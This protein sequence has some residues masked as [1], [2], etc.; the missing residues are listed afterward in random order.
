MQVATLRLLAQR[1]DIGLLEAEV[2]PGAC[3]Q[4]V[5][6]Q[7]ELK[8]FLLGSVVAALAHLVALGCLERNKFTFLERVKHF[9]IVVCGISVISI[10]LELN[11]IFVQ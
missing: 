9:L 4:H 8:L 6:S 2:L 3:A 1:V 10:L 11:H 5:S 7:V